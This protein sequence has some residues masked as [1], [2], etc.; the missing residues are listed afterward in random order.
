VGTLFLPRYK[1]AKGETKVSKVW[2]IRYRTNAGLVSESSGTTSQADARRLLKQ[3]EGAIADGKPAVYRADKLTVK[4]LMVGLQTEYAANGRKS[5][6]RLRPTLARLLPHFGHRKAM[7]VSAQDVLDYQKARQD[8]GAANATVNRELA[9]LKRAYSLAIQAERL[10]RCPPIR[11]LAERNVRTGFF[12]REAFE[13]VRRH[14]APPLAAMVTFAYETGWRIPSEVLALTWD[15][16]DFKAETV[17][18]NPG[19]TK[20]DEGRVFVFTPTLKACLVA[21]RAATDA[22]QRERGQIIPL[23]F[24]RNGRPIASYRAAWRNAC[25]AAGVPGRIPHDFRRTAVRNLERA[26][27]P[28]SVAMRMTGHKTEAVYR[29]YAIVSESDLREAAKKLGALVHD[30]VQVER[31]SDVPGLASRRIR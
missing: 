2:R 19:E 17:S 3:R 4:E 23:V 7:Q 24:H 13:A 12:E 27:V 10:Y 25:K 8:Q 18:L 22:C 9:A 14:L 29:R 15:R 28:R 20:N 1:N 6:R 5:I 11:A 26:G 21:Q 31:A 16:V 30:S